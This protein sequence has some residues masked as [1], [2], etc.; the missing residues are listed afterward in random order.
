MIF[1][2]EE[3]RRD[4]DDFS[5]PPLHGVPSQC[6][7]YSDAN[8]LTANITQKSDEE[9]QQCKPAKFPENEQ[10][11]VQQRIGSRPAK[12]F[13]LPLGGSGQLHH[14]IPPPPGIKQS[15]EGHMP[16]GVREAMHRFKRD[17][18]AERV[19]GEANRAITSSRICASID[20]TRIF[21]AALAD[22]MSRQ[23]GYRIITNRI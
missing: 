23:S 12:E 9:L 13:A 15:D 1:T 8:T 19:A 14:F 5:L 3:V 10:D 16:P 21:E 20:L 22:M 17:K 18:P 2:A 6:C 11:S 7:G 4:R